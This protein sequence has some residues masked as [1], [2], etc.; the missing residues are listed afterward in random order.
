MITDDEDSDDRR[1]DP[2]DPLILAARNTGS[3]FVRSSGDS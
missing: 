3:G 1:I 2:V